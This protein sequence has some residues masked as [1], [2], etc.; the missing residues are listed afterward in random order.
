V[1]LKNGT[2]F[3]GMLVKEDNE[4]V[5]IK[6]A[7]AEMTWRKDGIKEIVRYKRADKPTSGGKINWKFWR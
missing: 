2:P 7:A 3:T 4:S 5:T 6:A 1:I